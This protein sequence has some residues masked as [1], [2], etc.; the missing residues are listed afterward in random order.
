MESDNKLK[1]CLD[2]SWTFFIF[3][4][5]V[6][7]DSNV[8]FLHDASLYVFCKLKHLNQFDKV[9][10]QA[11]NKPFTT[12]IPYRFQQEE[13]LPIRLSLVKLRLIL[14]AVNCTLITYNQPLEGMDNAVGHNKCSDVSAPTNGCQHVGCC[15]KH[16]EP[17]VSGMQVNI[18]EVIS[19]SKK[20]EYDKL[21]HRLLHS[22]VSTSQKVIEKF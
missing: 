17:N 6:I 16:F 9:R 21:F 5:L 15:E 2:L 1:T 3:G 10:F 4:L 11:H 8:M 22:Y 7:Y 12:L 19:L 13:Q 20:R 14:G 18:L